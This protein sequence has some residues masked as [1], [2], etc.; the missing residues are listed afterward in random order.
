MKLDNQENNYCDEL[1]D[2]FNDNEFDEN[3]IQIISNTNIKNNVIEDQEILCNNCMHNVCDKNICEDHEDNFDI[4]NISNK[5][6][7][8][9]DII[10][11]NP[12]GISSNEL[13]QQQCSVA[14]FIQ[15]MIESATRIKLLD[16]NNSKLTSEKISSIVEYLQWISHTSGILANRIDQQLFNYI[17][18]KNPVIVR[19]SYNFC[20]AF[21]QCK[22]YYSK[23]E[24]P[25]CR[26]HH[27]V[28]SLLKYDVDSIINFLKYITKNKISLSDEETNNLYLSIKTICFVTRHMAREIS[29]IDYITKHNSE[30]FHRNNPIETSKR[31]LSINKN[32]M[33]K[34]WTSKNL[35]NDQS[36]NNNKSINKNQDNKQS[37]INSKNILN[38]KPIIRTNKN[39]NKKLNKQ[40][41]STPN[42]YVNRFSLLSNV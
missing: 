13:I 15:M 19:S 21:T 1:D 4:D 37:N 42:D 27:Y 38:Y 17:P 8:I 6:F 26:E 31:K 22:K 23:Y 40:E 41:I 3:T 10:K 30:V 24:I 2:W 35:N 25:T 29:Y 18:D 36:L 5:H 14:Y 12:I 28:H 32:L 16:T 39:N 11:K 34:K 7:Y 9:E 33:N 20:L